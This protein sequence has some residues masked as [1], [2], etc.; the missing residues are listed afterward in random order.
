M[1]EGS[2]NL[3]PIVKKLKKEKSPMLMGIVIFRF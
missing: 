2:K 1:I 3:T